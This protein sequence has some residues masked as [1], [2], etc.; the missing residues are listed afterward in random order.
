[1]PEI[2]REDMRFAGR[3][4]FAEPGDKTKRRRFSAVA[5]TGATVQRQYGTMVIDLATMQTRR[6]D[7]PILLAHDTDR[8]AGWTDSIEIDPVAGVTVKG[9]LTDKTD[10]GRQVAALAE[11]GFPWQMSVS[12]GG[13]IDFIDK[14]EEFE[15]NGRTESGPCYVLRNCFLGE[16]SFCAQG[17]DEMTTAQVFHKK[18]AELMPDKKFDWGALS[19]DELTA[20]RSDIVDAITAPL[21]AQHEADLADAVTDALAAERNRCAAIIGEASEVRA[22]HEC[23][24][25]ITA[26]IKDGGSVEAAGSALAKKMLELQRAAGAPNVGTEAPATHPAELPDGPQKWEA[27]WD[28]S[29][30]LQGEFRGNKAAYLAYCKHNAAGHVKILNKKNA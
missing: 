12:V 14:G 19:L 13:E 30:E 15:I 2:T 11:D 17:A 29:L 27:E 3:A 7:Q 6:Q 1:M 4:V 26:A 20:N 28:K 16:S 24:S 23:Y 5:Y 10:D 8:I 25:L 21:V 18:E 9:F 22:T